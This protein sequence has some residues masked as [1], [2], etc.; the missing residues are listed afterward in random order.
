[1]K[2]IKGLAAVAVT[3][4][5]ALA[6]DIIKNPKGYNQDM[7]LSSEEDR[8]C[9][10]FRHSKITASPDTLK[11]RITAQ[12]K[13][14]MCYSTFPQNPFV[15]SAKS[16]MKLTKPQAERLFCSHCRW[17]H[18][19]RTAYGNATTDK[20]RAR[21]AYNRIMFFIKTNGTDILET[22]TT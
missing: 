21:A 10:A 9:L 11:R 6:A 22:A 17:P 12:K 3:A 2:S 1:M 4:L 7:F 8:G 14:N 5:S 13:W 18:K 20:G 16:D 15:R 19:F